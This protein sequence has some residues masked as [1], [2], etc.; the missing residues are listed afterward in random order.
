[1]D[2]LCRAVGQESSRL[3]EVQSVSQADSIMD[4]T[5]DG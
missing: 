3:W 2:L 4:G 5:Q 1:M